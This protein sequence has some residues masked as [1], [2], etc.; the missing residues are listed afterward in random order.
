MRDEFGIELSMSRAGAFVIAVWDA[1]N[2]QA[3]DTTI[4]TGVARAR[5]WL[6]FL[7]GDRA[8][9]S[10]RETGELRV[11][12]RIG[13]QT[14]AKRIDKRLWHP[15]VAV[16]ILNWNGLEHT[17]E[18]LE[19]L[20]KISYPNCEVIVVD[21]G[22]DGNDAEL[23]RQRFGSYIRLI[24][25]DT[26]YGF[27]GG[28]NIGIRYALHSAVPD[29]VLLLNNDTVVDPEFLGW[30]VKTAHVDPAIGIVGAEICH[31]DAPDRLWSVWDRM[32]FWIGRPLETRQGTTERTEA[33]E[34]DS[35]AQPSPEMVDWA[36]G[37][38]LLIK[39]Q[40]LE[41]IGLL[42]ESYFIYWDDVEY[43]YRA[44][45][46][47][48]KTVYCSM[49]KVWHKVSKAAMGVPGFALYYGTRNRFWFVKEYA[50]RWQYRSFLIYFF[51]NYFWRVAGGCVLHW[52][53]PGALV[54]FCR[55]TKD[56]LR[57]ARKG[58]G[59]PA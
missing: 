30:M 11:Y 56:G 48:C 50:T 42:D 6:R 5:G 35:G 34:G 21:N 2:R 8:D 39:K 59:G 57:N 32:N 31:Y 14:R 4:G 12:S 54:S 36:T 25:N 43:C 17:T 28:S 53:H 37:C 46:A 9:A 58:T 19:S 45:K 55:G 29:Y 13:L 3:G 1:D 15:K 26:N 24:E 33:K 7:A 16:I 51:G 40:V 49:A 47:G 38:C 44:K 20:K 52:R 22:S 23:L 27:A 41:D 10:P 18:C